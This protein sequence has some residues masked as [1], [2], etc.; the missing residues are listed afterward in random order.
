MTSDRRGG[1]PPRPRPGDFMDNL[2]RLP[3]PPPFRRQP[4][5]RWVPVLLVLTLVFT[6]GMLA[7]YATPAVVLRWWSAE[8]QADA[9]AAYLKRQAELKAESEAADRRL[10]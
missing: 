5:L 2:E 6:I 8:A 9:E 4:P 3:V 1:A 7:L 10:D